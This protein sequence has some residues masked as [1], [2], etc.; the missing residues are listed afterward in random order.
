MTHASDPR[1]SGL[2]ID[3]DGW[4]VGRDP[5]ELSAEELHAVAGEK[6]SLL[7][8]IRARCID[9][10]AGNSAEVRKCVAVSCPNWP[11]RMGRRPKAWRAKKGFAGKEPTT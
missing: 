9:C 11:Y 7:A 6:K 3:A 10:C 1:Y 2:K 5:D 4:A 8:V